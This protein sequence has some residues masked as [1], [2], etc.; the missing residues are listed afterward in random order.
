MN[1]SGPYYS[2]PL[3]KSKQLVLKTSG[4]GGQ[5]RIHT[6]D[7]HITRVYLGDHAQTS[8]TD[9]QY[10]TLDEFKPRGVLKRNTRLSSS[11]G[12]LYATT[13]RTKQGIY[14]GPSS[15]SEYGTTGKA[16]SEIAG[17][18]SAYGLGVMKYGT[19]FISR[20]G[21]SSDFGTYGDMRRVPVFSKLGG[22]DNEVRRAHTMSLP[23][24]ASR[25][26]GMGGSFRSLGP[27]HKYNIHLNADTG[28]LSEPDVRTGGDIYAN[29]RSARFVRSNSF[30]E[31]DHTDN[32]A[33]SRHMMSSHNRRHYYDYNH[34]STTGGHH[35]EAL[36]DY[37][38]REARVRDGVKGRRR[39]VSMNEWKEGRLLVRINEE[40]SEERN[41]LKPVL[42]TPNV[43]RRR[44][45][46]ENY[47]YDYDYDSET[48][49]ESYFDDEESET[50]YEDDDASYIDDDYDHRMS[51]SRQAKT[52]NDR[53]NNK[54]PLLERRNKDG[55]D[56][57]KLKVP[58]GTLKEKDDKEATWVFIFNSYNYSI[59]I[60]FL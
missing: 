9:G 38:R 37:D 11:T 46:N 23:N 41:P 50:P 45:Y 28:Y 7:E 56:N 21:N 16:A 60:K 29:P 25:H 1:G 51:Q 17:G 27:R 33:H 35:Y 2:L 44:E 52:V 3:G 14:W 13:H 39:L 26:A 10:A 55:G 40:E 31:V 8:K 59:A 30:H 5:E 18:R 20:D 54:V 15:A 47:D 43:P 57:W 48:E 58:Q 6:G 4:G 32:T 53:N 22:S 36:D 12:N 42:S 34:R 49:E 24:R 19:M